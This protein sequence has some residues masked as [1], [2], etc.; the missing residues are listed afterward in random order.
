MTQ[1]SYPN[2]APQSCFLT[3]PD[4]LRLHY[5]DYP[6][7]SP[8]RLPLICLPG[9]ARSAEDFSRVASEINARGRRVIAID[10]RGRGQ[11]DWD[12]NWRGY[13]LDTEQ[14]DIFAILAKAEISQAVF[15]GTSRGGM[16]IMRICAHRPSLVRA[17][18]LN[19]IGPKIENDG[20]LRIKRYV[21]KLPP[22]NS[23]SDTIAL[24]RM[25]M[26]PSFPSVEWDDWETYARHTF[27]EKNGKIV[28]RYDPELSHTL[29]AVTPD[30]EY[31]TFWREFDF[32]KKVNLLVIRGETSDIFSKETLEEM[33]RI[34]QNLQSLTVMGQ[35]HAPLLLDRS[36]IEKI[37]LFLDGCP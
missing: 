14:S 24:M 9:L 34:A 1:T 19:D 32:L 16:H 26:A 28:L 18:I 13:T 35:G 8:Q 2:S 30:S 25:S 37:A 10:Y 36:T 22:L 20:L 3:V 4:G 11:S 21:G 27:I 7:P 33:K 29:D 12:R 15:L 23:M 5:L 17:A 6:S 31:E